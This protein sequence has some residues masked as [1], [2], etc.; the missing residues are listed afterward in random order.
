MKTMLILSMTVTVLLLVGCSTEQGGTSDLYNYGTGYETGVSESPTFR[1]G[2][3][4]RDIRDP[5]ALIH[6][7]PTPAANPP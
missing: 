5:N 3:N 1:P 2:M 6:P 4:P 7:V